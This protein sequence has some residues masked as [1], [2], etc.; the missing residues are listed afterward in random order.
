MFGSLGFFALHDESRCARTGLLCAP[1]NA[2][3]SDLVRVYKLPTE[4]GASVRAI[5]GWPLTQALALQGRT[6]TC[7]CGPRIATV[8]RPARRLA[9]RAWLRT[10]RA[11]DD[12]LIVT[13][14]YQ[15]AYR[16]RKHSDIFPLH[17][18]QVSVRAAR[19]CACPAAPSEATHCAVAGAQCDDTRREVGP[20]RMRCAPTADTRAGG[21][22]HMVSAKEF[23]RYGVDFMT[24]TV[25]RGDC[26]HN[27]FSFR[28]L[29][30]RGGKRSALVRVSCGCAPNNVPKK[31]V[32]VL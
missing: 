13:K 4:R 28:W 19:A 12:R 2:C 14:D 10:V 1:M 11:G 9:R 7:G 3:R 22:S 21:V 30:W 20:Q 26:F 8:R 6:S 15:V 27:F 17:T 29:Y 5:A 32:S 31:R 16:W 23:E 25:F 18:T 24:P